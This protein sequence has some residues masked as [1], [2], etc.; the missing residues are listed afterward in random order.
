MTSALL[1][2]L[3]VTFHDSIRLAQW[4]KQYDEERHKKKPRLWAQPNEK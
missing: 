3:L 4:M 1:T 2:W